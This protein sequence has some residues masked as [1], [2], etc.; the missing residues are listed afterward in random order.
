MII[1]GPP[2]HAKTTPGNGQSFEDKQT[3][4]LGAQTSAGEDG[5]DD[6]DKCNGDGD[7]DGDANI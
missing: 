6:N 7:G 1:T 2:K 3:H 4:V 5:D